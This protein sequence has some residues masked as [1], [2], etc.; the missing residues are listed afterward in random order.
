MT[1]EKNGKAKEKK[2]KKERQPHPFGPPES[3]AKGY[4]FPNT[5]PILQIYAGKTAEKLPTN[6][7]EAFA[8]IAKHANGIALR[9]LKVAKLSEKTKH[10]LIRQLCKHEYVGVKGRG[11]AGAQEGGGEKGGKMKSRYRV[12]PLSENKV[13]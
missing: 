7:Q 9:D 1:K 12:A 8:A 2:V 10:G 3:R 11:E 4:A 6:L 5:N 13:L